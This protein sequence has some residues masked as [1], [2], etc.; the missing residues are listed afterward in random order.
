VRRRAEAARALPLRPEGDAAQASSSSPSRLRRISCGGFP[1]ALTVL[2]V[3]TLVVWALGFIL[4]AGE[5]RTGYRG[6]PIAG[7]YR[8]VTNPETTR[9]RIADLLLSPVNGLYGIAGQSGRIDPDN[10]G[11]LYGSAGVFLFVLAAGAFAATIRATG[12]LESCVARLA[13]RMR[14]HGGVLIA[15]I[16]STFSLLGTVEGFAE[17]TLAFYGLVIPVVLAL[18]YDRMVALA[19]IIL[20][21]GVG[22]LA[23]TVNPFAIGVASSAAD[24]SIGD[25]IAPR[26]VVW[27]VVTGVTIAYVLRYARRVRRNHD[28]S[29]VGFAAGDHEL[30]AEAAQR[31]R[32]PITL[33]QK[34]VLALTALTFALLVFSV[35]PWARTVGGS[36][37]DAFW[38]ELDW[39]FAELTALFVVAAV[40]VG[41]VGRLGE[42]RLT[43]T[44]IKGAGEFLSPALVIVLARGVTAIMSNAQISASVLHAMEGVVSHAS[45]GLFAVLVFVVNLP[46]AFLIP[47]TSGHATLAI[48][49]L[50]PLGDF[51]G[52]KRS[53]VISGWDAASGW[54]ALITPT[55]AVVV[56]GLA[57]ARVSYGQYLRFVLP[58]LGI[59]FGVICAA[60][61]VEATISIP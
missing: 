4:P 54:A 21:A 28:A 55:T 47:S 1:N 5:Y 57:L 29:L 10:S 56:G 35:V 48:P 19:T 22:V 16:M 25:G 33:R 26:V 39:R 61:F 3:I 60:L 37:S 30:A 7:T 42:S 8:Q 27:F 11:E 52:V 12:A 45:S 31:A 53:V 9:E 15:A 50:A 59:L 23:G 58:L 36:E 44:L 43:E 13:D 38:W 2:A 18:G 14:S 46:L 6:D 17:E 40:V 51:A 41:V 24:V 34:L 49:I 20:G 32:A